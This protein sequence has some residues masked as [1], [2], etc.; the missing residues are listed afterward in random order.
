MSRSLTPLQWVRSPWARCYL[1]SVTK[2]CK[3][4][5]S[6]SSLHLAP[7]CLQLG[8]C[9]H[10][11]QVVF[12][13]PTSPGQK[14]SRFPE[15]HSAALS[16][17]I[18]SAHRKHSQVP[19][20][21]GKRLE[22]YLAKVLKKRVRK[23]LCSDSTTNLTEPEWIQLQS[24]RTCG[25]QNLRNLQSLTKPEI[26]TKSQRLAIVP[27]LGL[28]AAFGSN[29]PR[30]SSGLSALATERPAIKLAAARARGLGANQRGQEVG[31]GTHVLL[32]SLS[33]NASLLRTI[34]IALLAKCNTTTEITSKGK[35]VFNP[36]ISHA[37]GNKFSGTNR[38]AFGFPWFED[39]DLLGFFCKR[40]S[41]AIYLKTLHLSP[42]LTKTLTTLSLANEP[43]H[44]G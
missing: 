35:C 30:R 11:A 19:T 5:F 1:S 6:A 16:W 23:L 3:R 20:I 43:R 15:P 4:V 10:C 17:A 38:K 32:L 28:D 41:C 7:H 27:R 34:I 21:A 14:T 29:G 18:C 22:G 36:H 40:P 42:A 24:G 33:L 26:Q 12:S 25:L 13:Q 44:P 31:G 2:P 39:R 8:G 37:P 9:F